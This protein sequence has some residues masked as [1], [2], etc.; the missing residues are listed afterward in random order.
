MSSNKG[1]YRVAFDGKCRK[2]FDDRETALEW[3]KAVAETGRFVHVAARRRLL[4][5]K[6]VA[7]FPENKAEEGRR[8][9]RGRMWGAS[10]GGGG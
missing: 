3:A 9:W 5:P 4:G 1:T 7:I 6:L 8:L 2:S 10:A